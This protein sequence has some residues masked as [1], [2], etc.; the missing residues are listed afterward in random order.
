MKKFNLKLTISLVSF[1]ISIILL[2]LGDKSKYCL[3][4]GL[5]FI[6]LAVIMLA[7][8]KTSDIDKAIREIEEESQQLDK[9]QTAEFAEIEKYKRKLKKMKVRMSIAFYLFGGLLII[10]GIFKCF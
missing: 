2:V 5:I 3:S 8:Y 9:E 7:V 6:G 10:L 4:F 1:F